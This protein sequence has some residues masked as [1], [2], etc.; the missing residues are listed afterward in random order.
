ML[1]FSSA[2]GNVHSLPTV[3]TRTRLTMLGCC[4]RLASCSISA[5]R[6][7][8]SSSIASSE[9]ERERKEEGNRNKGEGEGEE[10]GSEIGLA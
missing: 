2:G 3:Q 7:F 10:G 1:E 5:T 9:S 4:P 8:K 6:S